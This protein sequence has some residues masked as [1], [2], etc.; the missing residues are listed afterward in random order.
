MKE[1]RQ[2]RLFSI[3][4]LPLFKGELEGVNTENGKQNLFSVVCFQV[5]EWR[6]SEFIRY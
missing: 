2:S 5:S 4:I 3:K 6:V 1:K